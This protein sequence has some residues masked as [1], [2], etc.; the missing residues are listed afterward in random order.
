MASAARQPCGLLRDALESDPD[1]DPDPEIVRGTISNG[2]GFGIGI[3]I[4][5]QLAAD[6]PVRQ[7][8][9]KSSSLETTSPPPRTA[10]RTRTLMGAVQVSGDRTM[11]KVGATP[12]TS[13]ASVHT[14]SMR[15]STHVP[16]SGEHVLVVA[17]FAQS[18][19]VNPATPEIASKPVPVSPTRR[20][21]TVLVGSALVSAM[22]PLLCCGCGSCTSTKS[23]VPGLLL[24]SSSPMA[25]TSHWSG[26][27]PLDG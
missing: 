13:A 5:S 16:L 21:C 20:P 10:R 9:Q 8:T 17:S 19:L 27:A 15:N 7:F 1:P 2:I 6:Q 22:P 23:N 3:G 11:M 25:V 14:P 18:A 12:S 24:V 26:F 4:D